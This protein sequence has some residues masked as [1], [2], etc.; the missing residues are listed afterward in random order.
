MVEKVSFVFTS[1]KFIT[2]KFSNI[3]SQYG[4]TRPLNSL[5]ILAK[6]HINSGKPTTATVINK[7]LLNQNLSVTDKKLTELL[8]VK[9]VE[10]DLPITEAKKNIFI[11]LTGSSAYKGFFGVY[12]FID[13]ITGLKY[14]GSSNLL[15]R[16]I[17]Y[18]LKGNYPLVGKFLPLLYKKGLSEFKLIIYKLNKDKFSI[19]DALILEQYYL[20]NKDFELN[21]LRV[22]NAGPSKGLGV[23]VY[24]LTCKTLYYHAKSRI[25]LK[26]VL[27]IHPETCKLYIDTK[28]P[29]LNK[30]LLLSYYVPIALKTTFSVKE[31][32]SI[33][34][35]ERKSAYSLGLRRKIPVILEIKEGNTFVASSLTGSVLNFDSLTSCSDYLNNLGLTIKRSTLTKYIVN[36]KV[37][38]NF[39]CTYSEKNIP[40]NFKEVGLLINEATALVQDERENLNLSEKGKANKKIKL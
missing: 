4:G 39:I 22:V 27:K 21:T 28:I 19:Q 40:D 26:R 13:K 30:F 18:Y 5:N 33:M 36:K 32:L 29:Y 8:D 20:L 25:E 15:R 17:E 9:G 12:I 3:T 7:I 34:H 6:E 24:D 10:L 31:I 35:E 23:Y 38:H 16:R 37:F 1:Y 2:R 14:V 11:T